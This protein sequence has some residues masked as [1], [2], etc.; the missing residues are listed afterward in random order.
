MAA[1]NSVMTDQ[2]ENIP[3]G[4]GLMLLAMFFFVVLDAA[5]K[6]L[7]QFYP[8][9]QVIWGRFFFHMFFVALA[10][11]VMRT[12]IKEKIVSK[13]PGIQIWR[14]ILMLATNALFFIA[15]Q[16]VELTTASAIM[17]LTP[18]VVTILAIP[19]LGEHV[20]IRRWVGV[21]IGFVGA[22]IIVRPGMIKVEM[23]ILILLVATVCHAF[24]SNIHPSGQSIRPPHYI[25]CVYRSGGYRDYDSRG[26]V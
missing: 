14:S 6:Y 15:I 4:I 18:I 26:S 1:I 19:V 12:R 5:A 10:L 2:N 21:L 8:V 13:K 3:A 22:L 23:A 11:L 25:P 9:V 24:L 16:T 20:G 17:F 7:M